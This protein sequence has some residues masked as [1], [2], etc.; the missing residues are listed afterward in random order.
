MES[1]GIEVIKHYGRKINFNP[2]NPEGMI[3]L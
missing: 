2:K 1:V 3:I